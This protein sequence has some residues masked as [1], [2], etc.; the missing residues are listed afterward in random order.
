MATVS[1]PPPPPELPELHNGDRMNRE[2]FHRIYE[3]MPENFRAELIEGIVY[4]ASPL[5]YHHGENHLPLGSLLFA[6]E[7]RTPG[8]RS[9]DNS[10]ILLGEE[11]E[12]QPDLYLR[13]LPECGGQSRT[14]PDSFVAGPPELIAEIAWSSR[15]IDLHGKRRDY[16]RYGVLEYLVLSLQDRQLHWFDLRA[17]QELTPDA[18]GVYRI[19]V[20]PGLW[21]HGGA[22]LARDFQRMMA[23][24]EQGL[25]TPEHAAF[26]QRL[27]TARAGGSETA[28]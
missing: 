15:G 16:T 26:V 13:I 8:V 20:M 10:T 6:Y 4:V 22:L 7:S 3:Q 1:N 18:D 27:A 11:G 28:R 12:P 21:I 25:A 23:T 17:N 5:K 9:G 14:T 24:L 2:E 19:R